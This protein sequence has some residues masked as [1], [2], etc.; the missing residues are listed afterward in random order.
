ML[1]GHNAKRQ[2][3]LSDVEQNWN[4]PKHFGVTLMK[5]CPAVLDRTDVCRGPER[6]EP[7]YDEK[8]LSAK[9]S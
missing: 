2:M 3:F 5:T 6:R 8:I 4:V 7:H 9:G 1:V